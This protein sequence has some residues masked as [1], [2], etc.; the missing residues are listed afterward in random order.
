V[1]P[2]ELSLVASI[3]LS[4][5]IFPSE[6]S[7]YFGRVGEIEFHT[8]RV[9]FARGESGRRQIVKRAAQPFVMV[10]VYPLADLP[11]SALE[12]SRG[13]EINVFILE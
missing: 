4:P 3:R 10:V 9:F 2:Q 8:L 1:L 11:V 6:L 7:Q 12:A 13:V 5:L